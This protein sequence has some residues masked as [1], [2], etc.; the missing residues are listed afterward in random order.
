M[1]DPQGDEDTLLL[2]IAG[3]AFFGARPT[4][5]G[6]A[7]SGGSDSMA[8]LHLLAAV[9][10]ERGWTV[11]AVTVDHGLRPEAADEVLVVAGACAK[12]GVSHDVRRWQHGE[13]AGNLQDQ[14]RR[15]RYGLIADWANARGIGHVAVGHT[16]DDQAETFLIELARGA[17]ID[18][19][20]AMRPL[21]ERDGVCW[22][23]PFLAE[24]RS[25]LR[26]CLERRGI[27]WVEDPSNADDRFQRIKARRTLTE[28]APLGI[29]ADVLSGVVTRLTQARQVVAMAASDAAHR[30]AREAAGAVMFD[31]RGYLIL[32][33]ETAWRLLVAAL[34]W[35]SSAEYPPRSEAVG[36]VQDAIREGRDATLAGCKIRAGEAEVAITREP[37]AVADVVAATDGSW[38]GRWQLAGPHAPG[39]QVRALGPEGLR[40][41]E[42]WRKTGHSRAALIVTPAVWGGQTL[43]AAPLA[44]FGEEWDAKVVRSFAAFVA[45]H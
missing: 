38:D 24:R 9:S 28:L 15:A 11:H 33:P 12:I 14:A 2:Q 1:T 40:Q 30:I 7:V 6:V 35:V 41:C 8:M 34:K 29:T 42:A 32:P 5:I 26:A 25:T 3:G 22:A 17:G 23:R 4:R 39:L 20:S 10:Q 21:W 18:G 27:G 16:A 45:S 31:R 43:V 36:R 44:G 37:R 13:I 19:L